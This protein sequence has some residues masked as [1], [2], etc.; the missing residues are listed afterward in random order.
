MKLFTDATIKLAGWYLLILMSVCVLFSMLIF[1]IAR[2]ELQTRFF[3]AAEQ[4]IVSFEE[5]ITRRAVA[6]TYLDNATASLFASLAYLNLIVLLSGGAG[7]YFLAR[8]T[9]KPIE[10][11]HEAQSRFVANAS[12]QF[13]T[14]L[15]VMKAESELVLSDTSSTKAAFKSVLTSNLEEINH[16]AN[17]SSMLLELSRSEQALHKSTGE[18]DLR[19]LTAQLV[20]KQGGDARTTIVADT[21]VTAYSHEAAVQEVL[22]VLIDN[23]LTHSIKKTPVTIRLSQTKSH[24]VA[25]F[26]NAVK[27]LDD[28]ELARIFERFY[29][30]SPADGYGLGL[31]LAHQ[32]TKALGGTLTAEKAAK[33]TIVFTFQ[34]PKK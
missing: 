14:P 2:D 6:Q 22:G 9:L 23:A 3:G 10:A 8:R 18:I 16:L 19:E 33:D 30:A 17:L 24:A 15:A 21:A 27:S 1:Q 11:A 5:S 12:H 25:T 7:A 31:P 26:T 13:R 4:G 34:L 32:L 29:R 20:H 28:K